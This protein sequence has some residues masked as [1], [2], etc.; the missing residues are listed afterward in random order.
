MESE[1]WECIFENENEDW[2]EK[3]ISIV[4]RFY[5]ASFPL[6][7]VSRKRLKDKLWLTLGLKISFKT[8]NKRYRLSLKK[9]GAEY[10][11]RYK[12]YKNLLRICL[13]KAEVRYY[14]DMFKNNKNSTHNL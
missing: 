6:V 9:P 8:K 4:L 13:H 14:N 1:N 2:Y 3:F 11:E 5:E 7:K 10:V 12:R